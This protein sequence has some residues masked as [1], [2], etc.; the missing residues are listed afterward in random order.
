M[1]KSETHVVTGMSRDLTVTRFNPNLVVDARNIRITSKDGNSTL[2]A[3]TNEKGTSELSLIGDTI[4]GNILG[5]AVVNNTLV[6]FTTTTSYNDHIYKVTIDG[7][8]EEGTVTQ[9]FTGNLKFDTSHPIETTI[10]FESSDIQ[11]VYWVDGK[12]Q[13]R[14]INICK[15]YV[16][17]GNEVFDFCQSV[18]F[19]HTFGI[20]KYTVGGE[21]P[22]GTIQYCFSYFNLNGQE[23]NLVDTSSL[24]YLSPSDRGLPADGK[25]NNSFKITIDNPDTSFEYIRL[26]S[27][28][29]T[30][31]N[32]TPNCKIVGD[33]KMTSPFEYIDNGINGSTIDPTALYFIGGKSI[34]AGTLDQKD[35]TLFLG[36]I[37][38]NTPIVG[39]LKIGDTTI[40]D[41]SLSEELL[42]NRDL[43]GDGYIRSALFNTNPPKKVSK[44]QFYDETINNEESS[45]YKKGFKFGE[46]YRLGFIAQYKTGEWSDAIWLGDLNESNSP[47]VHYFEKL[48]LQDQT[49]WV[50]SV[51]RPGFEARFPDYLVETLKQNGFVAVAPVVVFPKDAE[52]AVICQGVLSGT[53]F[54]V[55]DRADNSPF[56][57]A[58]WRFRWG[59]NWNSIDH[60]IQCNECWDASHCNP[61]TPTIGNGTSE[62]FV[63][64]YKNY[65]YRDPNILTLHSPDIECNENLQDSE[66]D[67]TY[68][69]IVGFSNSGFLVSGASRYPEQVATTY[70][71]ADSSTEVTG[72]D[73]TGNSY[74]VQTTYEL[75]YYPNNKTRINNWGF[76]IDRFH[77]SREHL[78][79]PGFATFGYTT[80]TNGGL[81][82]LANATYI[83]HSTDNSDVFRIIQEGG[84]TGFF[85]PVKYNRK[86]F[87]E[88]RYGTTTFFDANSEYGPFP[89]N[90]NICSPVVF[91]SEQVSSKKIYCT[92]ISGT[93][94]EVLYYGNIDRVLTG[95]Y[96]LATLF[97]T[98]VDIYAT[99]EQKEESINRVENFCLDW[100]STNS[101][102]YI[103]ITPNITINGQDRQIE[104]NS[105]VRIKYKSTKHLVVPLRDTTLL[106]TPDTPLQDSFWQTSQ[107]T[108]QNGGIDDS[109]LV[110]QDAYFE[111][112][113]DSVLI[114]EL[115]R[116]VSS[117]NLFGGKSLEAFAN[118]IWVKCGDTV[119]LDTDLSVIL[120]Y[121]EGDTY[122]GRYDCLKTYPST[123]KDQNSIVSIYSTELESRVNLDLRYDK[124]RGLTDNTLVTPQNFNLFNRAG[125]DQTNQFFTYQSIDYN[126]YTSN[127]F[128]NMVTW[129]LEKSYGEDVDTW[130][131]IPMT[132][133]I[134]LDGDKGKV[135]KV[136]TW[137]DNLFTFQEQG[138]AQLLYNSRVQIPVSDGQP[139]EITNNMKMAGKRYLSKHIGCFNKWSM[140]VSPLGIYFI[141]DLNRAI[142]L[143][144]GQFTSLSN[145]KGFDTW[146]DEHYTSEVWTPSYEKGIRAFYE[147]INKDVYFINATESLVFSEKINN[148]MSF[149]DYGKIQCFQTVSGVPMM[150]TSK[151]INDI[152]TTQAWHLWAG[153]YNSFFGEVKPYWLT[154]ISNTDPTVDKI[155]NTLDWRS[156]TYTNTDG[157]F[158]TLK[159]LDT[160]DTIRVWNDYQD[161]LQT[162]LELKAGASSNLKK[163]F[164]VFRAQIPRDKRAELTG[165]QRDRIRSPWA[166]VQLA[167]V[168][169]NY[170]LMVFND[171][172]VNFFE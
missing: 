115:R 133:T 110:A 68:L 111:N 67:G 14:V 9:L 119:S 56:V 7:I 140:V 65:Y 10:V 8:H 131:S 85:N 18:N 16:G 132:S 134:A 81:V 84:F 62:G 167:K 80:V 150:F 36:D 74:T 145:T 147:P 45:A 130:T 70:I 93:Q 64:D 30:S 28:I 138:I 106:S 152:R 157:V 78:C 41:L 168:K 100:S 58:D 23:T 26:Y 92:S 50:S 60:E 54:N 20:E 105:P 59:Y 128:P 32:A 72:T 35:N 107:V 63:R 122:L 161:T 51:K 121:K 75:N 57:Q 125:Y 38:L 12:N 118:N 101:F 109:A 148:F 102:G 71:D 53:V 13:P 95:T 104:L 88:L 55:S 82:C 87:S 96:P 98:A 83:W 66:L 73:S 19:G 158:G 77:I 49:Q 141:D 124:N 39:N 44:G 91:D 79:Y 17:L 52:R 31:E 137:N 40:S 5:S 108:L 112:I 116:D 144:N 43:Q 123:Q 171:L 99:V 155:Y 172:T 29:R 153:N 69:T 117:L 160:F 47:T 142:Y 129:S 42:E 120:E 164:N 94:K 37:K 6:L 48:G 162:S 90:L 127:Y 22:V 33:F 139:I 61:E 114:G 24:Y 159:P 15:N 149:M 97:S 156:T 154:F 76:N 170:D 89:Y 151:V 2:L 136:I 27:I 169:P 146:I 165:S 166:Y 163:K 113:K 3:V 46:N 103:Q 126:R 143:F 34:I 4:L 21:F 25:C 86:C 1:N 135:N 11:K